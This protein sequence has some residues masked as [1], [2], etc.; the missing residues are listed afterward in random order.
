MSGVLESMAQGTVFPVYGNG[1]FF[2]N[3]PPLALWMMRLS[4]EVL[5][6]SPFAARLPSVL[7]AAATIAA[8]LLITAPTGP[9]LAPI[10]SHGEFWA[11]WP[12]LGISV[13][14]ALRWITGTS[15]RKRQAR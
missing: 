2:V 12:L 8:I 1:T 15:G 4:S 3:K 7:A 5:G 9:L 10:E 6:P 13:A 11:A 14:A